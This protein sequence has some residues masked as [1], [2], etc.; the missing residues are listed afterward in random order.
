MTSCCCDPPC[1]KGHYET[2]HYPAYCYPIKMFEVNGIPIYTE[3]CDPPYDAQVFVCD[4]YQT[5]KPEK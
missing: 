5:E 1:L 4:Q 3:Q 2:R